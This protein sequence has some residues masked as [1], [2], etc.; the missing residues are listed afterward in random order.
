MWKESLRFHKN[1]YEDKEE[2]FADIPLKKDSALAQQK[3]LVNTH[4]IRNT[5]IQFGHRNMI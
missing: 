2:N 5:L 1:G 4:L 3:M